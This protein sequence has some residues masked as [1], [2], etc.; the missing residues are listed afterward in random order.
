MTA[1]LALAAWALPSTAH[2]ID[3][4]CQT[5]YG[6][7]SVSNDPFDFVTCQCSDESGTGGT[8][9][10]DW[11]EFDAEMLLQIC[12]SELEFCAFAGTDG[13]DTEGGSAGTTVGTAS[14]TTTGGDET[15]TTTGGDDT[16]T[17]TSG[18]DTSTSGGTDTWPGTSETTSDTG[19]TSGGTSASTSG[20]SASGT[21][22]TSGG[23][24]NPDSTAGVDDAD[25]DDGGAGAD[26][27]EGG[28]AKRGCSVSPDRP[29][30]LS[31]LLLGLLGLRRR[32]A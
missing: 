25:T 10:N 1:S 26:D 23:D 16:S 24:A 21:G 31:L 5:E 28:L 19:G 11:S 14:T 13:G 20:A 29:V 9:V 8:G 15:S 12:E 2:A 4:D 27:D 7:C 30:G 3:V 32:D 6:S 18:D 17:T 22:T